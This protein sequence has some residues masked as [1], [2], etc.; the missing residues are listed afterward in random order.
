MIVACVVVV[1]LV[2]KIANAAI[3]KNSYKKSPP[4]G[5]LFVF[6]V[7]TSFSLSLD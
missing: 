2:A 4:L 5:G 1:M 3:K 6:F 7:A